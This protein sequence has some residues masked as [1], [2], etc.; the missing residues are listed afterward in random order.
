MPASC[1]RLDRLKISV[2]A[3]LKNSG[4]PIVICLLTS[5]QMYLVWSGRGGE[6]SLLDGFFK[7]ILILLLLSMIRTCLS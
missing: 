4:V 5:M 3:I 2:D 7:S 1:S 6:F